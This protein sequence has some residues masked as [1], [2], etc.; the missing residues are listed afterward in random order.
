MIFC[1][2]AKSSANY[3]FGDATAKCVSYL[4]LRG[5]CRT[6]GE[7]IS[8]RY[9]IVETITAVMFASGLWLYGPGVLLASR[10]VL[11]CALIVLFE[12][13]REHQILPHAVTL[14]GI[15]VGFA[16]SFFTEPGWVSSLLGA[17]IG[18]A[19]HCDG[20]RLVAGPEVISYYISAAVVL[21]SEKL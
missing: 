7:R 3:L 18:G 6:C 1:I 10:L 15:A 9:P 20:A 16:F 17:A 21:S 12:I 4:Y 19:L 8:P 11:G 14:P 13:D 2:W 5:R